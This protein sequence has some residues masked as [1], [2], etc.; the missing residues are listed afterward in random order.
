MA[1]KRALRAIREDA[2]E[3]ERLAGIGRAAYKLRQSGMSV[4]EIAERLQIT[5]HV[6]RSG[7]DI[8][9]KSAAE[10][11]THGAK[12]DLLHLE[13]DRLDSL[14]QSLWQDAMGGNTRAVDSILKVMDKRHKLLGLEAKTEQTTN[15]AVVIAGDDYLAGLKRI[16][17]GR[18]FDE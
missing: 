9:L 10:A 16:S 12:E 11:M 4:F 14:Q 3:E 15:Q 6:V 5:E 18:A 2:S 1:S 8:T 13:L 7:L 17:E